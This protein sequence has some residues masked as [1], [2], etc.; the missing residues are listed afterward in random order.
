MDDELIGC[1]AKLFG[2]L[3]IAAIVITLIYYA[4]MLAVFIGG[5]Y[6]GGISVVNY[7]KS[8]NKNLLKKRIWNN[9]LQK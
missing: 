7:A 3:I 1:I 8:F 6:G 2:I 5:A 9:N 4:A